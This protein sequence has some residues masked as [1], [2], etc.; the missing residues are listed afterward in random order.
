MMVYLDSSAVLRVLLR[1]PAPLSIWRR[2][3][4]AYSSELLGVEARRVVDR[5][6]LQSALDDAG[7]ARAH[8]DLR[9][10]ERSIDTV[11]LTR[12]VLRRAGLP[13]PTV[14]KTLDGIHLASALLLAERRGLSLVF[15]THDPQQATAARALG[16]ECA[17]I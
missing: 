8:E 9:G 5:L 4:R 17:G 3:E 14:V 16:F 1:Q 15:A 10:I 7:V 13:M 6:R 12:T 2:W 11:A